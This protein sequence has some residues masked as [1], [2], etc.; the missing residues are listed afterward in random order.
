[1]IAKAA[2]LN[3]PEEPCLGTLTLAYVDYLKKANDDILR[4]SAISPSTSPFVA[5]AWSTM[6]KLQLLDLLSV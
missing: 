3:Q 4:Y 1:M 6:R 5:T 2:T